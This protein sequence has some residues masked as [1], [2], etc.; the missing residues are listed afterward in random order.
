MSVAS[1]RLG[2]RRGTVVR[3]VASARH[4]AR[5]RS[6]RSAAS[7]SATPSR[8]TKSSV[9]VCSHPVAQGSEAAADAL[10]YHRLGDVQVMGD[11]AVLALLDD[12]RL[13][14]EA[15]IG[16]EHVDER[17]G[18]DLLEALDAR[19]VVVGQGDALHAEAALGAPLGVAA[20]LGVDQLL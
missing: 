10:A 7:R 16:D 4:G 14:G 19:H 2:R 9:M 17:A 3:A 15:L 1:T 12:V 5:R 6:S 8:V 20:P 13:D 18:L 11:L